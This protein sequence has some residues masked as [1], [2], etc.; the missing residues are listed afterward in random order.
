[1]RHASCPDIFSFESAC[2]P[3]A[4]R[5]SSGMLSRLAPLHG[6]VPVLHSFHLFKIK[7]HLPGWGSMALAPPKLPPVPG[8]WISIH[9]RGDVLDRQ[10]QGPPA[11]LPAAA[12]ARGRARGHRGGGHGGHAAGSRSGRVGKALRGHAGGLGGGGEPPLGRWIGQEARRRHGTGTLELWNW[13][14]SKTAVWCNFKTGVQQKEEQNVVA[15][16]SKTT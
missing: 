4:S 9:L 7:K 15:C 12:R 1:M 10:L 14:L 3:A 16:K 13:R 2:P 11:D 8:T 5:T 6:G